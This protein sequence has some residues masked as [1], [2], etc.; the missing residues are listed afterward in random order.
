MD[1]SR[2]ITKAYRRSRSRI[3]FSWTTRHLKKL[4]GEFKSKY[5]TQSRHF[6]I[7]QLLDEFH[8]WSSSCAPSYNAIAKKLDACEYLQT[9]VSHSSAK[10]NI[11][12]AHYAAWI[13][14]C[15]RAPCPSRDDTCV[16]Y[17]DCFDCGAP[18]DDKSEINFVPKCNCCENAEEIVVCCA[19]V[20]EWESNDGCTPNT[21]R[22]WCRMCNRN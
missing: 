13:S 11:S 15:T 18:I 9:G 10:R 2:Q 16:K 8:H 4:I 12:S 22:P 19:C 5:N 21:P 7:I 20:D 3:S 17:G 14:P 1:T 6:T